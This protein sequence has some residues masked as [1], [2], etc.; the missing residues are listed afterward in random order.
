M[1]LSTLTATS[2]SACSEG[3]VPGLWSR[4]PDANK[5][6]PLRP[7]ALDSVTETRSSLFVESSNCAE[8]SCKSRAKKTTMWDVESPKKRAESKQE[9]RKS[10]V[11][12]PAH[13]DGRAGAHR[14]NRDSAQLH[15]TVGKL[16]ADGGRQTGQIAR[17][18]A[19]KMRR[20]RRREARRLR[21]HRPCMYGAGGLSSTDRSCS[22]GRHAAGSQ[23]SNYRGG[24]GARAQNMPRAAPGEPRMLRRWPAAAVGAV[25]GVATGIS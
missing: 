2:A 11:N 6:T 14:A 19:P 8:V 21:A 5:S 22:D 9:G 18:V 25:Q 24:A 23:G 16:P 10:I 15:I 7:P 4:Y 13:A 1:R 3:V 20:V 12:S 17:T